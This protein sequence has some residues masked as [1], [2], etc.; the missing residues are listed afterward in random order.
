M[1]QPGRL[2]QYVNRMTLN[3]YHAIT[4]QGDQ[5]MRVKTLQLDKELDE[6]RYLTEKYIDVL[7]PLEYLKRSKVIVFRHSSGQICGGYTLVKHGTLRVLDSIPAEDRS[8]IP[9][10]LSNVAEITGLWLDSK[11]ANNSFCSIMFWL[12]LYVD[13]TF[14]SFDGFVY[15][16]T[17]K[18][19]NLKKTYATFRPITLFQGLTQQ[20]EGMAAP[21]VEAVEY[22]TKGSVAR[23]PL[24]H[25]TFAPRRISVAIRTFKLSLKRKYRRAWTSS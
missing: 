19:Q 25:Y 9:V 17:L 3:A 1:R 2:D 14:S 22:I 6:Y 13:L 11:K 16:Y 5:T 8:K 23:S 21:E 24:L 10:D 12:R 4:D 20:L 18:K 15:A 7:L